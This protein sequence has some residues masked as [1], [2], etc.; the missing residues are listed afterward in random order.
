MRVLVVEDEPSLQKVI[1]DVFES[2]SFQTDCAATG[3]D[4]YFLA[5]QAIYDLI[6][7]DIML[8]GMSGIDIVKKLREKAIMTPIILLTAKDSLED[9]VAGLDAGADDYI[10]KPFAVSELLARTRAVLRR[11]GTI[12][13][14]G[15][16]V[17]GPIRLVPALRD[18]FSGE[19]AL[20]LTTKEYDLLEFF[21]CNK[22][23][24][25]TREQILH[26]IWGFDSDT[27][28]SAVDV[29]VHLLRKKLAACGVESF[30]QTIRGAGYMF[31]GEPHVS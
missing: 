6:V 10:V 12:H 7:L 21:M 28:S 11:Q 26:R 8:P 18:A 5:E 4:G 23:Q 14:D 1:Q 29:Y 15:L 24:I 19:Q 13:A 2:E 16:L 30:L 20:K 27:A 25:L 22:E 17:C 9:R 31:K 3:D